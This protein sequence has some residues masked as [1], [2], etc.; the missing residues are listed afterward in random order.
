MVILD[1]PWVSQVKSQHENHS[2]CSVSFSQLPK[3]LSALCSAIGDEDAEVAA[4]IISAVHVVGAHI[5]PRRWMPMMLDNISK[6]AVVS[7]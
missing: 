1:L 6:C 7:E 4:R 5:E 2:P 3:L